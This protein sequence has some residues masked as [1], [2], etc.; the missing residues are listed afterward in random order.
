MIV[1]VAVVPV[2]VGR[3]VEMSGSS[4]CSLAL[5]GELA[6][7]PVVAGRVAVLSESSSD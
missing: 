6:G 5:V 4:W 3:S 2:V 7:Q 1:C